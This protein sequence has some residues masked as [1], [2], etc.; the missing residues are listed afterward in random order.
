MSIPTCALD[1]EGM[2]AQRERYA[3][4]GDDVR[5][6]ER[7]PEAAVVEFRERFD[8]ATLEAALAVERAC[9]PFFVFAFDE[10]TRRLR[11][12]VSEREQVPALDALMHALRVRR[13]PDGGA[14]ERAASPRSDRPA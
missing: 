14:A 8:R 5:R 7:E 3:A 1:T 9:C 4:L 10:E 6:I 13:V 11:V 12:T 2:R